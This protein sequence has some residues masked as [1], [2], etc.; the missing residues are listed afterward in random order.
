MNGKSMEYS[1]G[2]TGALV[3]LELLVQTVAAV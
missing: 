2:G 3:T 1:D